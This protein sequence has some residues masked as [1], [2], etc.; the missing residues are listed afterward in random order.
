M[1][2]SSGGYR[3][4]TLMNSDE[5]GSRR[6]KIP[7]LKLAGLTDAILGV[8][9]GVYRELGFGFLE[10]V[11]GNAMEIAFRDAGI[12]ATREALLAARFRGEAIGRFRADFLVESLVLVELKVAPAISNVHLS[13]VLNYLRCTPLEVALILNFG[14]RPTFRRLVFDNSRKRP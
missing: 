14:E 8:Y 10:S 1:M 7:D 6:G 4:L 3:G 11:Y 5:R 9:Y 2:P 12:D 13:Q